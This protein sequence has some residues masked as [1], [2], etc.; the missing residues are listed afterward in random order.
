[1]QA[2]EGILVLAGLDVIDG[3]PCLDAWKVCE[4]KNG[5]DSKQLTPQLIFGIFW[6]TTHGP[7]VFFINTIK[8]IEL[9]GGLGRF[10]V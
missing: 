10:S 5:G 2:S 1:M 7:H 6:N 9:F 8:T 3:T 4:R